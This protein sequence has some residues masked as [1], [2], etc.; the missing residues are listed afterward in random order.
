[1]RYL[2]TLNHHGIHA[3]IRRGDI[4]WLDPQYLVTGEV[5][6]YVRSHRDEIAAEIR[7]CAVDASKS[8]LEIA[9]DYH[10]LMVA[11]NLDFWEADDPR[12][13]YEVMLDVC[14]RQLDAGYYA[15]LRHRMENASKSHDAGTLDES[16]FEA[17][18]TQFNTIHAWALEHIGQEALRRAIRSANVKSYI[19]PSEDTFAAYRKTWDDAWKDYQRRRVS[20]N[21]SDQS[22]LLAHLL[23][24]C[25]YAGIRSNVVDDVVLIIR[26]DAVAVPDT[27]SGKV[28][29]TMDEL[30]LMVGSTPEAVKQIHEVKRTMGG[31]VVF[32][33]GCPF[34]DTELVS[35][36]A[37][38]QRSLFQSGV[39]T[40]A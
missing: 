22:A 35:G 5:G 30:S 1:M 3:S 4:L 16:A 11:T 8:T 23:S 17:L 40:Y 29:F 37:A 34:T 25:G 7:G 21:Q 32:P 20:G 36:Q 33:D 39:G 24:T 28:R 15:W 26:D 27:W 31:T 6:H 2:D 10:I 18:R 9:P 38:V 19:P 14:Y 12:F 13:G